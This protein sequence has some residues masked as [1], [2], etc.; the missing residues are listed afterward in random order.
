MDSGGHST[1]PLSWERRES[2]TRRGAWPTRG[3]SQTLYGLGWR[4]G[5]NARAHVLFIQDSPAAL[6]EILRSQIGFFLG[7]VVRVTRPLAWFLHSVLKTVLHF[8]VCKMFSCTQQRIAS[9]CYT[10]IFLQ[11]LWNLE[12]LLKVHLNQKL[13]RHS[14]KEGGREVARLREKRD[15]ER[16]QSPQN[17]EYLQE[18]FHPVDHQ[19]KLSSWL[20]LIL[21]SELD[22]PGERSEPHDEI[23]FILSYYHPCDSHQSN[24]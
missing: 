2:F 16:T 14:M 22:P 11:G 4:W 3:V 13:Y 5:Q 6:R 1:A 20:I 17:T 23:R 18:Q 19:A 9:P 15:K 8:K 12:S 10:F 7:R 21:C 24:F